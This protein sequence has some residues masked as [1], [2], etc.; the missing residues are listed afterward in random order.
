MKKII[1]SA[2]ALATTL[3]ATAQET[4]NISMSEGYSDQVYFKLE[5]QSINTFEASSWDIAFLRI[6]PQNIGIR[7]N[8]G[9]GIQVFEAANDPA[10][11]DNIAIA[12][13]GDWTPLY[14]DDTNWDNGAFMQGS[15]TF[16]WG[17]YNPATH[18]VEGTI[19]FVLKYADGT[20]VKFINEDYFG[21]YTFKY[22]T[23]NGTDWVGETTKVVENASNP[24]NRYN[25]Y[26]F[27]NNEEVIAEPA[28]DNWDFVFTKYTTYLDPPAAYY[29]VTGVLHNPNVT[30][31]ENEETSGAGDPDDQVYLEEI[32]TIG[33]DWKAFNGTGYDVNS[34]MAY[35]VKTTSNTVYRMVFTEFNGT[36]TGD[37]AFDFEDVSEQLG[38]ETISEGISF[39]MYPNPSTNGE[40]TLVYDISTGNSEKNTVEIYAMNGTRVFSEEVTSQDGFYNKTINVSSLRS[41]VY[42]VNF[43]S[44]GSSISKKLIIK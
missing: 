21:A 28:L 3:F 22:A 16:G 27:T 38:F 44:G 7:V 29:N 15:A 32:N 19:V 37:I 1:L 36:A 39:G 20:Y 43:I 23:W 42:V 33:Y 9:A 18:H 24:D 5:D 41:G 8:D 25:Y 11:F 30:V 35:Y 40:V 12:N 34:N 31:A 4:V 10:E 26:S 14:N 17:E 6:D 13:E 2:V